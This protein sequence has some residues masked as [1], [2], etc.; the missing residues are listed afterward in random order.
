MHS[1]PMVASFHASFKT[2]FHAKMAMSDSQQYPLIHLIN[3]CFFLVLKV[4]DSN[5]Y[6]MFS[7]SRNAQVT[8]AEKP[9]M[10]IKKIISSLY[11]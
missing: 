7:C 9:Q 6:Y 2:F 3:K 5:N 8:F 1:D 10:K 4:L 11:N